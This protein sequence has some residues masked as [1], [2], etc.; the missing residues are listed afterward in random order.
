MVFSKRNDPIITLSK[1]VHDRLNKRINA[2]T[3]REAPAKCRESVLPQTSLITVKA[4]IG[5]SAYMGEGI[6]HCTHRRNRMEEDI[7]HLTR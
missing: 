3:A 1:I 5:C 4:N 2:Q 7:R 6:I